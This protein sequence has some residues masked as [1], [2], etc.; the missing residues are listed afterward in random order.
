MIMRCRML[1]PTL[2]DLDRDF[3]QTPDKRADE[4]CRQARLAAPG[5]HNSV[6]REKRDAEFEQ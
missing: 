2:I 1:L 3:G 5:Y 4:S 6:A